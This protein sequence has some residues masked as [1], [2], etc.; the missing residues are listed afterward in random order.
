[1]S[2]PLLSRYSVVMVRLLNPSCLATAA[3]DQID[4][5]HERGAYTDLLLA[6]LKKWVPLS[7]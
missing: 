1:M 2:D 5:A 6:L 3:N 4:E 7:L